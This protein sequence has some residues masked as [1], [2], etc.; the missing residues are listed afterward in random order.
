MNRVQSMRSL[1]GRSIDWTMD[2]APTLFAAVCPTPSTCPKCPPVEKVDGKKSSNRGGGALYKKLALFVCAPTIIL[3][4]INTF[5]LNVEEDKGRENYK[6]YDYL[7]IRNK[8]FPWGDGTKSLFH[9]PH[10]NALPGQEVSVKKMVNE[11]DEITT[12]KN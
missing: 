4:A 5:V 2:K 9:N 3:L 12:V 6:K 11:E 8:R 10:K 7:L 1:L